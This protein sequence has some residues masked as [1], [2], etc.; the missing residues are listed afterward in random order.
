MSGYQFTAQALQDLFDISNVISEDNPSALR[1]RSFVR[2]LCLPILRSPDAPGQTSPSAPAFLGRA[3]V[4]AILPGLRRRFEAFT[5]SPNPA[6]RS[7]RQ[8]SAVVNC[9]SNLRSSVQSAA[10]RSGLQNHPRVPHPPGHPLA[11]EVL[12]QRNRIL[13]RHSGQ[14]LELTDIDFH[15]CAGR[16]FRLQR[17]QLVTQLRD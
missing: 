8:E 16:S 3:A 9:V 6:C 11:V 12:E 7:R 13:A 1:V 14:I 10:Q 15:H 17:S 5:Y 2:V 4:H